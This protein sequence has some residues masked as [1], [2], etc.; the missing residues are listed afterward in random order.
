MPYSFC[1]VQDNMEQQ[2]FIKQAPRWRSKLVKKG[3][4]AKQ[5]TFQTVVT[6]HFRS[7]LRRQVAAFARRLLLL[8]VDGQTEKFVEVHFLQHR[9]SSDDRE[10][11]D[12]WVRVS[13]H[14]EVVWQKL[15][16]K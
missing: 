10:T 14:L 16:Q 1:Q 9:W 3:H 5:R 6:R 7:H 2:S 4:I 8:L 15:V 12:G 13:H 11:C